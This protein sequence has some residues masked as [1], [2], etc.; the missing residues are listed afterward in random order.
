MTRVTWGDKVFLTVS[1]L[2]LVSMLLAQSNP[3]PC[4]QWKCYPKSGQSSC[5]QQG[6]IGMCR[7]YYGDGMH[8]CPSDASRNY[9][10]RWASRLLYWAMCCLL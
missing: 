8:S 6:G 2:L 10:T 7:Y 4:C 5:Q 3:L 1:I 9:S